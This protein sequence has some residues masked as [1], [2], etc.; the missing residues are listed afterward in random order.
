[1]AHG[2][3]LSGCEVEIRIEYLV[4]CSNRFIYSRR[5]QAARRGVARIGRAPVSKTGGCGF[6]SRHPCS[7]ERTAQ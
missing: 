5:A 2:P 4:Y 1:M 7:Y 6:E 3:G